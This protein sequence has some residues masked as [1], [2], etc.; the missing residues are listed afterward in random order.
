MA[1]AAF[2]TQPADNEF[3]QKYRGFL[4]GVL[5][6]DDLST[7]WAT[8]ESQQQAWFIYA[9]G[10]TPPSATATPEQLMQFLRSIDKLLHEEHEEDY[11]GIVYVDDVKQPTLVKIYDPNNLGV[12]CGYSDNPPLPG[13][14]MSLIAPVDLQQAFPPTGSRKRWWQ[15]IFS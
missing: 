9:V 7:L 6:W 1:D 4:S 5:S 14:V 13:W 15:K 12:V 10:E 8:I 3:L 2:A 11:C